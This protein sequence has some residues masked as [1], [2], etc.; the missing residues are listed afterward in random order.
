MTS[1]PM[2]Q[3][4]PI[5]QVLSAR[6]HHFRLTE[7]D[8]SDHAS[9]A[10]YRLP[11]N[12][13]VMP[14]IVT[15]LELRDVERHVFLADLVECADNAALNQRPK[16]LDCLSVNRA[17]DIFASGVVNRLVRIFLTQMLVSDPLIGA[18]QADLVRDCLSNKAFQGCGL[19][20]LNDAGDN[21]ASALGGTDHNSFAAA[22]SS[23]TAVTALVLVPIFG[24]AADESFVN[25]ND[26]DELA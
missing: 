25:L 18:K 1:P 14:I 9:A 19:D 23:A 8:A 16:A 22:A 17:D 2:A 20:V 26:A 15:E 6:W 21:V 7:T 11:E 10:C 13:G 24:E 4:A 3:I 12:I 5:A